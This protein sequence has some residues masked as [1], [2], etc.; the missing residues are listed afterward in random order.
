MQA[1]KTR[2][3]WFLE[4][5]G[6][7]SAIGLPD[8]IEEASGGI[9]LLGVGDGGSGAV[10]WA[11]A[12]FFGL[13]L[14]NLTRATRDASNKNLTDQQKQEAKTIFM[15]ERE[16]ARSVLQELRQRKTVESA[17]QAGKPAAEVQQIAKNG[18][19]ALASLAGKCG[20][21]LSPN[22]MQC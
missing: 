12:Q 10:A 9:L 22:S 8:T 4:K 19:P 5:I 7:Q 21:Q 3:E 1:L 20:Q 6:E 15:S 18:G 13:T 16:G 17:I 2:T 14:R 11:V